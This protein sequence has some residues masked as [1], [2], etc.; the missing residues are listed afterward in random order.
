MV[1]YHSDKLMSVL[2]DRPPNISIRYADCRMPLDLTDSEL[3]ASDPAELFRSQQNL[4]HDGWSVEE[5][6]SSSTWARL[7][8]QVAVMREEVLEYNFQSP[9]PEN[10]ERLKCVSHNRSVLRCLYAILTKMFR[11]LSSRNKAVLDALPLHLRYSPERWD[12][13][14]PD[15]LC[16]ML[17]ATYLSH[18]QLDFQIFRHLEKS[19]PDA[20][21]SLL[22]VSEQIVATVLR[23]GNLRTRASFL[24]HDFKFLVS[25]STISIQKINAEMIRFS[26]MACQAPLSS[27][28]RSKM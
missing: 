5:R 20:L 15:T 22:R 9:T 11:N 27:P 10:V 13:G 3:L 28:L 16:Y 2:D 18:C 14:L 4:T 24:A 12:S 19:D 23:V 8:F 1:V 26:P 17:T 7:R 21:V 6:Y 25:C